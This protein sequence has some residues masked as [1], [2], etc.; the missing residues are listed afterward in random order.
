MAQRPIEQ[1]VF[2][3]RWLAELTIFDRRKVNS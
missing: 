2:P 1:S 3:V